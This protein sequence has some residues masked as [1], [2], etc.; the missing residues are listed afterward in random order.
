MVNGKISEFF[1][2]INISVLQGSILG[3]LLFLISI[4]DM[5]KSNALCNVHFADDTTVLCKKKH[6]NKMILLSTKS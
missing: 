4:N 2:T 3:P 5:D 6:F 1:K